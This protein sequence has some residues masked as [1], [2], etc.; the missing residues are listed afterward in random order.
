MIK[1]KVHPEDFVVEEVAGLP[2][3][4]NG[5]FYVYRLTKRGWNT[6]DV[7]RRISQTSNI[8]FSDISYGGKKDKH[9]ITSQYI[10]IAQRSADRAAFPVSP[11]PK[12]DAKELPHT[13]Q[14]P[15]PPS[16][17]SEKLG[18]ENYSMSLVGLMDRSMG[19]DLI[20][21]NR[22]QI[23]VRDVA[24]ADLTPALREIECV[25][26]DGYPNYFDDQR[27]GSF[28]AR[29]GFIAEKIIKKHYNGALRAYFSSIHPE[30]SREEKE[31]RKYFYQ[32]WGN[33]Q[34]CL[35]G[36]TSKFEKEAF[37]YLEKHSNG[38]VAI[39][40]RISHE[41]MGLF[42]SA[43]QSHLWNELLRK[44]IHAL[45]NGNPTHRNLLPTGAGIPSAAQDG[46]VCPS[47]AVI[48]PDTNQNI[49]PAQAAA[50]R[51][52][53]AHLTSS[54]GIAGSYL[55]PSHG[56]NKVTAYLGSLVIPMPASNIKMPDPLTKTLYS[57]LLKTHEIKPH[58]FNTKKIRDG[59][60][61]GIE[62]RAMVI[63]EDLV[64]NYTQD[65]M[66]PDNKKVTLNFFLP[67]ACYG[68]M[69][70]KRIFC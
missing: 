6:V 46:N 10:T 50:P 59:F 7:L 44:I 29:Q 68:T 30:D 1:I 19:S 24:D 57:E 11:S 15:H 70:I 9:A 49:L 35:K 43:Y 18:D 69:F 34:A 36:A 41:K 64:V 51:S 33:W 37:R 66:Y 60:F 53:G 45:T 25:K 54:K 62:R 21:G 17:D 5:N 65:E 52:G 12:Q 39:L 23:T 67:K 3:R 40:Q 13:Q 42:F 14:S 28:D 61:K 8:P 2:M 4:K 63:P 56:D 31:Y 58:M 27:F 47:L 38:F 16:P 48:Y 20:T 32:N 26:N 55:F 22:F